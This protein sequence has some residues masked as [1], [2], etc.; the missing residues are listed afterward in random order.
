MCAGPVCVCVWGEVEG[1][2]HKHW[3]PSFSFMMAPSL[4]SSTASSSSPAFFFRNFLSPLLSL[5]S[6]S[7]VAAARASV[8][9]SNLL[10]ALSFTTWRVIHSRCIQYGQRGLRLRPCW[11]G[12]SHNEAGVLGDD[13]DIEG[14]RRGAVKV[15]LPAVPSQVSRNLRHSP[16]PFIFC[17][18]KVSACM[19]A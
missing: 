11:S 19:R 3:I 6:T 16:A 12:D 10:N 13:V 7:A 14:G 9:F 5:L 15:D 8:V 4:A 1:H 17:I 18:S 2:L